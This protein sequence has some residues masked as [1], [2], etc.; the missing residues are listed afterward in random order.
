MTYPSTHPNPLQ[1]QMVCWADAEAEPVAADDAKDIRW[2]TLPQLR[3]VNVR[4]S[5][6]HRLS[7]SLGWSSGVCVRY[8]AACPPF[9]GVGALHACMHACTDM[10]KHAHVR[11]P[12]PLQ[13]PYHPLF[14]PPPPPPQD[15]G[16]AFRG[17]VDVI[18]TVERLVDVGCITKAD[19][20]RCVPY[21]G[22]DWLVGACLS[23]A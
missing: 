16:A 12:P 18:E 10:H 13:P 11:P 4:E 17:V 3:G 6:I 9:I 2:M 20:V 8:G 1:P 5:A 15:K 19:L 22:G 21:C 7:W 23:V 14:R